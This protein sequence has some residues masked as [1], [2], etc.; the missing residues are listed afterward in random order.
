[1]LSSE[2][3][4]YEISSP[5]GTVHELETDTTLYKFFS[6]RQGFLRAD[7]PRLK[8]QLLNRMRYDSHCLQGIR[9]L[10]TVGELPIWLDNG[11]KNLRLATKL[12]RNA[13]IACILER[14]PD[15]YRPIEEVLEKGIS[16][17]EL[18]QLAEFVC[19]LPPAAVEH[20][21]MDRERP[22]LATSIPN[23]LLPYY[24]LL[25]SKLQ[26]LSLKL[27][28]DLL[29]RPTL[30]H[31]QYIDGTT[32]WALEER[33][34]R[35]ELFFTLRQH[36]GAQF[37]AALLKR[38][39]ETLCPK[40]VALVGFEQVQQN[41][42]SPRNPEVLRS[43]L[44]ELFVGKVLNDVSIVVLARNPALAEELCGIL[45]TEM[46]VLPSTGE[47]SDLLANIQGLV[48]YPTSGDG[49]LILQVIQELRRRGKVPI[50]VQESGVDFGAL[51]EVSSALSIQDQTVQVLEGISTLLESAQIK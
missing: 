40:S 3:K 44:C 49:L 46:T 27:A 9:F 15:S 7:W 6:P 34:S 30:S 51:I 26:G 17:A 36:Y 11:P 48:I 24:V 13:E 1:M 28:G 47:T 38:F 2:V 29:E 5:A 12:P 43:A 22:S 35:E 32:S 31:K 4:E 45:Q 41:D 18:R 23:Y 19:S 50:V 10:R 20:E 14:K 42:R 39:P 16:Q 25:R 21:G 37:A 33:L 8:H